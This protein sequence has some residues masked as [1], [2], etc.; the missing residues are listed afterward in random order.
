MARPHLAS[1]SASLIAPLL[2]HI[3]AA[4]IIQVFVYVRMVRPSDLNTAQD[5][6]MHS[7]TVPTTENV[8]DIEP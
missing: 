3:K 2:V 6:W 5:D 4:E 1:G 8:T 7:P